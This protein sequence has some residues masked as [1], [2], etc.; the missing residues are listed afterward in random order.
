MLLKGAVS[1]LSG[2]IY[3][4]QEHT[5]AMEFNASVP[6]KKKHEKDPL[7]NFRIGERESVHH[8]Q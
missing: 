5:P 8:L 3:F 2:T 4:L 7:T 1:E 6:R